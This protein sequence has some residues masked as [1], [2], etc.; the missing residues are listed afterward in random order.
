MRT[1][2]WN[3]L[4]GIANMLSNQVDT[5]HVY[6]IYIYIGLME[7]REDKKQNANWQV[8]DTRSNDQF[9][10]KYTAVTFPIQV[11]FLYALVSCV[12]FFVFFLAQIFITLNSMRFPRC[13]NNCEEN[14]R[15]VIF[16]LNFVVVCLLCSFSIGKFKEARCPLSW[17]SI[18]AIC[19]MNWLSKHFQLATQYNCFIKQT[20]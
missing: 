5:P 18:W 14:I 6:C 2:S 15:F 3:D 9:W 20:E 17:K 19:A 8:Q 7:W 13:V 4:I 11:N 16:S 1:E 10:N 12:F